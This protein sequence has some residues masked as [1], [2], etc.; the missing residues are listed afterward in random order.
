M[1]CIASGVAEEALA[2]TMG[3][4]VVTTRGAE[5]TGADILQSRD[6]TCP[7]SYEQDHKHVVLHSCNGACRINLYIYIYVSDFFHKAI[8]RL[9]P[10]TFFNKQLTT[11]QRIDLIYS[12]GTVSCLMDKIGVFLGGKS[13]GE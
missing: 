5:G 10:K 3:G 2:C 4:S 9:C 13:A 7:L 11:S 12:I 6:T 8:F 1:L